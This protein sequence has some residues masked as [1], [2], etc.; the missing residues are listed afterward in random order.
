MRKREM[1]GSLLVLLRKLWIGDVTNVT[2]S[3]I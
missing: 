2:M 3:G 1:R